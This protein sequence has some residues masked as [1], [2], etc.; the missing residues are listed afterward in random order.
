MALQGKNVCWTLHDYTDEH[1]RALGALGDRATYCVWGKEV[2]PDTERKHLQGYTEFKSNIRWTVLN[3]LLGNTKKGDSQAWAHC[4]A[5]KGTAQE[6]AD[7]CK[8][9]GDWTE[10]GTLSEP[11]QQG[12]RTDLETVRRELKSEKPFNQVA[13]E[14]FSTFMRHGKMMREFRLMHCI[15]RNKHTLCLV[16][17]GDSKVG[18]STFVKE[19]WPGAY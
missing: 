7:Y 16:L 3:K 13:D 10:F 2:C 14:N 11:K 9:D 1:I 18:K 5:R 8:K 15:K 19:N 6:A 12:K 4:E 17:W